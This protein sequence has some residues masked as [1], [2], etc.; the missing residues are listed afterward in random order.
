MK[1]LL[2]KFDFKS[3]FLLRDLSKPQR[4]KVIE[5]FE[6]ITFKRGDRLFYEDGIPTGAFYIIKGKAKKYK[7]VIDNQEQIF[8]IYKV[9]DLLGYHALLSDERYQDSCEALEPL[10]AQFISKENLL[11]LIEDIPSL[12]TA[13]MQNMAHEFGVLANTIAVLAQKAQTPR[14]ALFL[15]ILD[16]R[17]DGHGIELSRQDLSNL[18]GATRESVGRTLKEF[19]E[20]GLIDIRDK[21][22]FLSD[23]PGLID[24]IEIPI[25]INKHL[26]GG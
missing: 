8:Y 2:I 24:K 3:D 17:Y 9:G 4:E 5:C 18:I 19:K 1:K 16:N 26:I 22:I 12:K 13:M 6:T 15:L 14:L 7:K 20:D 10:T 11:Q 23:L 21:K 25:K